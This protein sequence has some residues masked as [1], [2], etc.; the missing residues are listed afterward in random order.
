MRRACRSPTGWRAAV[1]DRVDGGVNSEITIDIG[2]GK[3]L[4]SVITRHSADALGLQE[5]VAVIALFDAAHV[6]L[7]VD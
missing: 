4:T 7:A 2:D 5:G 1:L 3:T 6:I